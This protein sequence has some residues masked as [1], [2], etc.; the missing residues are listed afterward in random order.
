MDFLLSAYFWASVFFLISLYSIL[1]YMDD[2]EAV[3]GSLSSAH[4]THPIHVWQLP[5]EF[6]CKGGGPA[7]TAS[8]EKENFVAKQE[9]LLTRTCC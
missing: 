7:L 1:K 5:R 2:P 8:W 3:K 4:L 9:S 6:N